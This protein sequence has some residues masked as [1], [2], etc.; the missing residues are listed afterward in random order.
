[1]PPPPP[2]EI[3][4][5]PERSQRG[6]SP[7]TAPA[8]SRPLTP[9]S[10]P[11]FSQTLS[12]LEKREALLNKKMALELQ[13]AKEFNR[14]KNKRAA[15]QCLKKKKLY[16]QQIENLQ[17]HQLKLEEQVIT[18]E[19]SKTTAE[20]FS[21]LK[22]GAGAMKQLH[23]ETN[24]DEVDRVM[25]D[26]N[27]QSEKMRQV[28][29]AL[30][31]PW[32]TART[33]TRTSS[34][35]SSR[36]WR[37][38]TWRRNSGWRRSWDRRRCASPRDPRPLP[39]PPS[40]PHPCPPRRRAPLA[41]VRPRKVQGGRRARGAPGGDGT[42]G[43]VEARTARDGLLSIVAA[44]E[45]K[46]RRALKPGETSGTPERGRGRLRR[47]SRVV[48]IAQSRVRSRIHRHPRLRV[49]AVFSSPRRW[50]RER[51][52]PRQPLSFPFRFFPGQ[53]FPR[54]RPASALRT[55]DFRLHPHLADLR[56][57][58][59]AGDSGT[60]SCRSSTFPATPTAA[61]SA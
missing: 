26:I 6:I 48:E 55:R 17:N 5:P 43:R 33:W 21:A 27:E 60:V 30:G 35:P 58:A 14:A 40:R 34:T 32:G 59:S 38:R 44:G 3:A 41:P 15:L 4:S 10:L 12:M 8:S 25:D 9:R 49:L 37:R 29:E 52:A 57:V 13:K 24:I 22:S 28:Q 11:P 18:L 56:L 42:S 54:G 50:H 47:R 36:S 1:M 2:R 51:C 23:K 45:K 20:T 61:S 16:E 46:P 7:A 19:G 39:P 53:S 31:Q